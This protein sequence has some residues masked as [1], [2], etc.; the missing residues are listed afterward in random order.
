MQHDARAEEVF[1]RAL[2]ILDAEEN[3]TEEERKALNAKIARG[4]EQLDM[5]VLDI[6]ES[7]FVRKVCSGANDQSKPTSHYWP[8]K[9]VPELTTMWQRAGFE[10]LAKVSNKVGSYEI[11]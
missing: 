10:A 6:H 7:I 3:W 1:R 5:D 9:Y 11:V 4:L 2:E 8:N